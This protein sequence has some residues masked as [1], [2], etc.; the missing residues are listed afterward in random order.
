MRYRGNKVCPVE[1]T[2][3]VDGQPENIMPSL[4]MS[5]D[6]DIEINANMNEASEKQTEKQTKAEKQ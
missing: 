3:A 5:G 1:R 2:N 4:T 6:E